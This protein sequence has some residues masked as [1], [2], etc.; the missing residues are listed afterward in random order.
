MATDIGFGLV[1]DLTA[2]FPGRKKSGSHYL[3]LPN[4]DGVRLVNVDIPEQLDR[5]SR[6]LVHCA[7]GHGRSATYASQLYASLFP[8]VSAEEAYRII[9]SHR[10]GAGVSRDQYEQI[11]KH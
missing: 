6:V 11:S 3:C 10:P 1:I 9:L 8:E 2:E 5:N 4:L 7:Q